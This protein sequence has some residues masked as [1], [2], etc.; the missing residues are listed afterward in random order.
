MFADAR[1]QQAL[2]KAIQERDYAQVDKHYRLI[3]SGG[4]KLIVPYSGMLGA[5]RAV[6]SELKK[7]GITSGLMKEAAPFTITVFDRGNLKDFAEPVLF[8]KSSRDSVESGYWILRAQYE[9]CYT[10]EGGFKL[11]EEQ[12]NHFELFF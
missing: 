12:E 8:R 1:D 2:T 10:G 5:Y 11:P 3:T 9:K 7:H 4:E 6:C